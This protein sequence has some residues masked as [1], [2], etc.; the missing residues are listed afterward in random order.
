MG[1]LRARGCGVRPDVLS[2]DEAFREITALLGQA[3]GGGR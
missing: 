1:R 2:V 3:G